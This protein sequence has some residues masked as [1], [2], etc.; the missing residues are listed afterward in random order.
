MFCYQRKYY[1]E[2]E[3][4]NSVDQLDEILNDPELMKQT[5]ACKEAH[6]AGDKKRYDELKRPAAT[7][8]KSVKRTARKALSATGACRK[9]RT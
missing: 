6:D 4:V 8:R 2:V 9:P 5:Q 1:S 7:R 3:V